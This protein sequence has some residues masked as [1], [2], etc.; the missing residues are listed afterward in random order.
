MLLMLRFWISSVAAV[1]HIRTVQTTLDDFTDPEQNLRP[2]IGVLSLDPPPALTKAFKWCQS[3]IPASYIKFIEMA[4]GRVV[5]IFIDRN[6]DYYE[7]VFNNTNGLLIPG[8]GLPLQNLNETGYG[9]AGK[10]LYEMAVKANQN[11]D[12][13]PIWGTCL[14]AEFLSIVLDPKETYRLTPCLANNLSLPLKMS[15]DIKKSRLLENVPADVFTFLTTLNVTAN[16]HQKCLTPD[17]VKKSGLNNV[18]NVLSTSKDR[19]S[20]EFVSIFEAIN[21]PFYGVQWHPEKSVFEWTMKEELPHTY[22]AVRVAQ[23]FANFFV[24]EARKSTHKFPDEKQEEHALIYNQKTHYTPT[25]NIL[26]TEVYMFKNSTKAFYLWN[27]T[28]TAGSSA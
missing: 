12:F 8:G 4:G 5:P 18:L 3:Y 15:D 23:H 7:R 19:N 11:N 14:G 25:V 9:R 6:E 16:F 10:V 28:D 2:I 21:Y 13:Y 1:L 17:T 24:G 20:T 27:R 26:F 22:E